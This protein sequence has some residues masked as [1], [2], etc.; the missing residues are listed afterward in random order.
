[1]TIDFNC[2]K[3]ESAFEI[4]APDLIDGSEKLLCP[5][6]GAK[7][8][9]TATDDFIAAVAELRTQVTALSKKFAVSLTLES[10]DL[11]EELAPDVD[12]DEDEEA[13]EDDDLD[14]DEDDEDD[15]DDDGDDEDVEDDAE[16]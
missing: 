2:Q 12:E 5:H 3:C 13:D 14:F 16:R 1:M 15:V 10:E 8:S 7:P 9:Q 11:A 6:C 4:E